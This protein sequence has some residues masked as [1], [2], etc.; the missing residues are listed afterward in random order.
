MNC[1]LKAFGAVCAGLIL[2]LVVFLTS[3]MAGNSAQRRVSPRLK[4]VETFNRNCARCHGGDGRGDTPSGHL[5]K[6]PDFTDPQWWDKNAKMTS[7]R[8]L[9]A[10]VTRGKGA[11]P[12]FGKKLTRSEINSLVDRVRSFRKLERKL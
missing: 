12:A 5:F 9:R 1:F 11:M 4:V 10:V 2:L 3:G 7:P 8:A 6:T